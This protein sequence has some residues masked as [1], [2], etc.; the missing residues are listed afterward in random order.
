MGNAELM[1]AR[2]AFLERM[3]ALGYVEGKNIVI[4]ERFA[5]GHPERSSNT[6]SWRPGMR[7]GS[8]P[9]VE[10]HAPSRRVCGT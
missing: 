10:L 4:E 1:K 5:E 8:G 7:S 2:S 6:T 3:S 9:G